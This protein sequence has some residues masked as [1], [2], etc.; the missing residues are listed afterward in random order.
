M[1][2]SAI[3]IVFDKD[4]CNFCN[5]L[6]TQFKK[7]SKNK[8]INYLVSEIKRNGKGKKYD[9]LI[10]VSGGVDS[11]YVLL[12]AIE[13]GLRPLVVHLDNG[14]N[15]ELSQNNISCLIK[16]FN[17][18]FLTHV[19]D[20]DEFKKL[21]KAYLKSNVVDLE[22]L[23]DH[24]VYAINFKIAKKYKLKYILSGS[25]LAT[26]GIRLPKNWCWNIL[27]R[28][29]IK[30]I[31]SADGIN[32]FLT[33][34]T[35]GVLDYVFY[36]KI[37][38][39]KW[40][41]TLDYLDYD[42]NV[43]LNELKKYGYKPYPYK[44]YESILTRFYQGYILPQKFGID[45]RKMFLSILISSGK[46]K[47]EEAIFELTKPTYLEQSLLVSDMEFFLKKIEWTQQE[48]DNYILRPSVEHLFYNSELKL[49]NIIFEKKNNIKKIINVFKYYMDK[50]I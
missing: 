42:K 3:D 34:P 19:I 13:L 35:M 50:Y 45:K 39:I 12:K 32:K 37:L 18:D 26:E 44:H 15:S 27:D 10:G 28:E 16:H 33:Y 29:N 14:W 25:N 23:S 8:S 11:S 36:Y 43:A 38:K 30:S 31:A 22:I 48:L 46:I 24:A 7:K 1:D 5:E 47:R 9:C 20:W 21:I 4:G 2:D 40:I 17:I 41:Y 6:K 49:H